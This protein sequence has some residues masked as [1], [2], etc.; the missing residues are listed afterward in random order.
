MRILSTSPPPIGV[1]VGGRLINIVQLARGGAPRIGAATSIKRPHWGAPIEATEVARL[2]DVLERQG[3][4][5]SNIVLAVPT[6]ALLTAVLELPP[7]SSGAPLEQISRSELAAAHKCE[8]DEIESAFWEL[9]TPRHRRAGTSVMAVGCRTREANRLIDTF[10]DAGLNVI[11]LDVRAWAAARACAPALRSGDGLSAILHIGWTTSDLVVLSANVVV[12]ERSLLES[13]LN[14]LHDS[15]VDDLDLD[16]DVAD[17]IFTEIGIDPDS[18]GGETQKH[19]VAAA[20]ERMIAHVNALVPEIRMSLGYA[21]QEYGRD[22]VDRLILLGEAAS[23]PGMT[24]H[25]GDAFGVEAAVVSPADLADPA[26]CP[27][28]TCES[29]ALTIAFGLAQ[30]ESGVDR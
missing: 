28:Q 4:V 27:R 7:K 23:I 16:A 13:G 24:G 17:Y 21:A 3:F 26:N 2:A 14:R 5:G 20:R 19:L 8:P 1:D 22:S 25:L 12:Y 9:P 18:A 10:E 15:L 6:A 30:Y 29:P 11:G